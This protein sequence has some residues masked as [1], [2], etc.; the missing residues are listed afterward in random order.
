MNTTEA[1]AGFRP[2]QEEATRTSEGGAVMESIGAIATIA[3]A[4]I[5]LAGVLSNTLTAIAT[6]ILGAAIWV[7]GGSFAA[8]R[9]GASSSEG[10]A[11]RS[12][13]SSEGLAAE[14]LGGL[15]AI[16]LGVLALLGIDPFMLL[17]VATLVLGG[18]FL[19]SGLVTMGSTSQALAGLTALVLG[20]LAIIG[21]GS[22]SLVMAA[23]IVL[24]GS[25][26][27]HGAA[28]S[29]RTTFAGHR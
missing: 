21:I 20:L 14:F 25:A 16:V 10:G 13:Q 5:A 6:I 4:I 9:S 18:G 17:A 1:Q 27:L 24:G 8:H 2:T 29:G 28:T 12:W 22:L 7:E 23:L 15:T 11:A 3:L 26:L 19:L